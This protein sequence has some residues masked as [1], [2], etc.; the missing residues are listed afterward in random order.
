ML[1]SPHARH[2]DLLMTATSTFYQRVF[3]LVVAA[4]LGYALVLIFTPFLG[5]MCWAA[6][7]AFLLFPLNM[8]WGGVLRAKGAAAG[9]LTLLAP[10]IILLPLSALSVEFVAQISGCCRS[11]RS[12]RPSSTSRRFRDL[13]QFPM[14]RA[15]QRLAAR[16]MRASPPSRCNRGW[17]P[18][19]AGPAAGG[20]LGGAFFLGALDR[21]SASRS[22]CFCCSFFCATAMQ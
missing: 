9:V 12:R 8:R 7:L 1:A 5:P 13:Q 21:C 22:C 19:P 20:R 10:I 2:V 6:F 15:H 14:D 16:S 11:C 4:A 18:A 17:C 3:A